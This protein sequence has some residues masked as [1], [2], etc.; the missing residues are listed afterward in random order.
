LITFGLIIG[1]VFLQSAIAALSGTLITNSGLTPSIIVFLQSIVT[2]LINVILNML[3]PFFLRK[4]AMLQCVTSES[5]VERSATYK[6]FTFSVYQYITQL[7]AQTL[8]SF[9][10]NL[11]NGK[12][13]GDINVVID[14]LATAFV[15]Q[16]TYFITFIVT[17]LSGFG[18]SILQI[19]PLIV[20]PIM[21]RFL[22]T[23]PREK[24]KFK[25]IQEV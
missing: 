17:G 20:N 21:K 9:V 3:L 18:I 10:S 19:S 12:G 15:S 4:I 16:S 23:T 6:F 7:A 14:A 11:L 1:W 8:F 22:A 13:F 24:E 25:D 2:P 5:G